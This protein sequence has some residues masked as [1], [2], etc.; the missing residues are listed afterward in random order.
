VADRR[1]G[2]LYFSNSLV[3]AGTEE[4]ILT[5]L[6]GLDRRRF[7]LHLA[8]TPELAERLDGDVPPDVPV[9]PLRLRRPSDVGG[10]LAL[11]RLLESRRIDVLHSHLFWASLFA[12][13]VG[14]LCRVPLVVETPHLREL[15][16]RGWKRSY[17]IDRL[18]GRFVHQ[19]IAVS[20]ANRRYLLQDKRLPAHKIVVIHN[21]RDI[22]VFDPGRRPPVGLREALGFADTDPVL[23]VVG[24][25]EP[26]KGHRVLLEALPAIRSRFPSVRLVCVGEGSLRGALEGLAAERHLDDSVRFVG[27]RSDVIDWLALADITVL[28]SFYEG[29]PLAAIESLAAGRPMVATDVD[30]SPE[31][32]VHERTGLLVPPGDP[33]RL[34]GAVCRLLADPALRARLAVAGR[35]WVAEL[36]DQRRQVQRTAALYLVRVSP[37]TLAEPRLVGSGGA[38]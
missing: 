36:F 16:R 14:R 26:Q 38:R 5:L 22:S 2:V 19:Y 8:C 11:A 23:V 1:I 4:H 29:L 33:V 31:V 3:R 21:G 17:A 12:S 6:R 18:A 15:W 24:R 25:L 35:H 37:H 10:A 30:G 7:R 32:V 9:F 20:E 13:P 34:A 27:H 28:P